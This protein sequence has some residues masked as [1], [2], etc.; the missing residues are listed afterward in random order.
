MALIGDRLFSG[1]PLQHVSEWPG[2]DDFQ[3]FSQRWTQ[4]THTIWLVSTYPVLSDQQTNTF[5]GLISNAFLVLIHCSAPCVKSFWRHCL[6]L[7]KVEH[8]VQGQTPIR[9]SIMCFKY[10][11]GFAHKTAVAHQMLSLSAT[12]MQGL[13]G[14]NLT[15]EGTPGLRLMKIWSSRRVTPRGG[16]DT[17]HNQ[18]PDTKHESNSQS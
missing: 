13:K 14:W 12:A 9:Q 5:N 8:Y 7:A 18:S 2:S 3:L 1:L 6:S 15:T 11:W 16:G 10:S 4:I 17:E